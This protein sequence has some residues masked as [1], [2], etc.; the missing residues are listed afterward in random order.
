[1]RGIVLALG[2]G[3]GMLRSTCI[4]AYRDPHFIHTLYFLAQTGVQNESGSGQPARG[5]V[6]TSF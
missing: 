5:R 6:F 3:R 4:P 1:M 2:V